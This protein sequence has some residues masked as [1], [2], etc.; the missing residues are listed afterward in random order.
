MLC[1]NVQHRTCF[2]GR[3]SLRPRLWVGLEYGNRTT[4][5]VVGFPVERIFTVKYPTTV[6]RKP[7]K[8][9]NLQK[10]R[11]RTLGSLPFFSHLSRVPSGPDTPRGGHLPTPL[12]GSSSSYRLQSSPSRR[13]RDP[14]LDQ[15]VNDVHRDPFSKMKSLGIWGRHF[16]P[17]MKCPPSCLIVFTGV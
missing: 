11:I 10:R 5:V 7:G 6:D 13:S 12:V 3:L 2:R 16:V 14:R 15:H 8:E 1:E 4:L 9:W 17:V